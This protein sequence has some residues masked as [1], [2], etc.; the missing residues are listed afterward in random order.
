MGYDWRLVALRFVP[1]KTK[2]VNQTKKKHNLDVFLV[3]SKRLGSVGY[4]P[5]DYAIYKDRLYITH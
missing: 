3:V 4:N 5:K 1:L 2:Q